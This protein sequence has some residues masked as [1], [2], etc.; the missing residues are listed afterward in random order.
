MSNFKRGGFGGPRKPRARVTTVKVTTAKAMAPHGSKPQPIK[1][2]ANAE[3]G[4]PVGGLE[5]AERVAPAHRHAGTMRRGQGENAARSLAPPTTTPPSPVPG[6]SGKAKPHPNAPASLENADHAR[7]PA[8]TSGESASR[9][10]A[11]TARGGGR[12]DG[13]PGKHKQPTL[14]TPGPSF[15]G[16]AADN[17][18]GSPNAQPAGGGT[19]YGTMRGGRGG[20]FRGRQS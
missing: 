3:R 20:K 12:L 16:G 6:Q 1:P 9:S 2:N 17:P 14:P 18:G 15:T 8:S 19:M 5:D 11:S 7:K 10:L 4:G 13:N